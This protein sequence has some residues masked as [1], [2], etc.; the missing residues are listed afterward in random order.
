MPRL[1]IAFVLLIASVLPARAESGVVRL[2]SLEWPPYSSESAVLGGRSIDTARRALAH[3]GMKLEVVYLPWAR[4]VQAGT[5]GDGFDGYLPE[6]HSDAI[7]AEAAG[8]RCL[9]SRSIGRSPVGILERRDAP[10]A[11]SK[12]ADLTPHLFGVVRGYV[13][14]AQFDSMVSDDRIAV[15]ES[16]DDAINIRMVAAKRIRAAIIDPH[17]YDY[18]SR[19]DPTLTALRQNL[20]INNRLL[21]THDL[22]VCF[23]PTRRGAELRSLFNQG[24]DSLGVGI[25]QA[26]DAPTADRS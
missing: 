4:T 20:Q 11:W 25:S 8:N 5:T 2:A 23:R 24:L 21:T 17:V 13:N 7:D 3:V 10:V 18:L 9:F 15:I 14:E 1:A 6:Y 12:P 26:D 19:R 16:V 22:F